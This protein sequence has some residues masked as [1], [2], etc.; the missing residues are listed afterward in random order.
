MRN[1]RRR[2]RGHEAQA[3]LSV[4]EVEVAQERE[5][6]LR[7]LALLLEELALLRPL[8][9]DGAHELRVVRVG[10]EVADVADGLR[11]AVDGGADLQPQVRRVREAGPRDRLL[12]RRGAR[13]A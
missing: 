13:P 8:A 5:L 4:T 10:G 9:Q 11:V 2:W 3:P 6:L 7:R 12:R 1:S